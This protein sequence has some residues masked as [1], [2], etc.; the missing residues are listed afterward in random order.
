MR[1]TQSVMV[2]LALCLACGGGSTEPTKS[3]TV[4]QPATASVS[5]VNNAFLPSA[6]SVRVNGEVTW[7]WAG[8]DHNVTFDMPGLSGSGNLNAG[9]TF[10]KK[11]ATAGT[12]IYRCTV[13]AMSGSVVVGSSAPNNPPP[14]P[15]P[16]P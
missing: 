11:F 1:R 15:D 5:V 14:G 12:F 9:A 4:D 8:N 13:H 6:I 7:T 3:N 16:Y 2:M 10:T